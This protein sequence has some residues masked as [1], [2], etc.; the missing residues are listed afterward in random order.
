[1]RDRVLAAAAA[2][3]R[4]PAELTCALNLRV[5]VT[6]GSDAEAEVAGSAAEVAEQLAGFV[7]AGFSALNLQPAGQRTSQL[8]RIAAEVVPAVRAAVHRPRNSS[9][10]QGPDG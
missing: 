2:A 6:D 8:E 4:D 7:A 5:H 10:Q 9:E 3:G 1:M